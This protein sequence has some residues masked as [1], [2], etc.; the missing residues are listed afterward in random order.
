MTWSVPGIDD[1]GPIKHAVEGMSVVDAAGQD[2]GTVA[3]VKMGDPQAATGQGQQAPRGG[4][5][6]TELAGAFTAGTS[7]P[8]QQQQRLVRLGYLRISGP[9]LMA[10]DLYVT[11]D[12]VT[13]VRGDR[14]QLDVPATALHS[15]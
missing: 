3:E 11:A 9:G 4:G 14:V 7:M 1:P 2:V 15:T 10:D 12:H 6:L 8:A 13:G 5:L